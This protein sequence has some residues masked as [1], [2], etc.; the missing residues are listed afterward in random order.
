MAGLLARRDGGIIAETI[1][2]GRFPSRHPTIV[3][4]PNLCYHCA[5]EV[6]MHIITPDHV[7]DIA[8]AGELVPPPG[9]KYG[10]LEEALPVAALGRPEVWPAA[11]AIAAVGAT[12]GAT[13][14][15]RPPLGDRRFWLVRLACTLRPA[16][17]QRLTEAGLKLALRGPADPYAFSLFPE[18][19]TAE[20]EVELTAKLAPSLTFVSGAAVSAGELGATIRFKQVYPVIESYGAGQAAVEWRFREDRSRP[21]S[22][23]Q[24]VYVTVAARPGASAAE[25]SL[26]VTVETPFGP[27][28]LGSPD[29]A[30]A[31]LRFDL[32][33]V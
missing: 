20:R 23:D 7:T 29:T 1:P 15:W 22:G 19:L 5:Q 10:L 30:R 11:E 26:M 21:L 33:A 25:L 28:R 31:A 24:F 12:P 6:A 27:F 13:T 18:R 14:T 3:S 9:V 32:P 17:R 16:G 8:W 2:I 4:T